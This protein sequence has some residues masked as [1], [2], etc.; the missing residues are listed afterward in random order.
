MRIP[1][2]VIDLPLAD[3]ETDRS[4]AAWVGGEDRPGW[5]R[6]TITRGGTDALSGHGAVLSSAKDARVR[7]I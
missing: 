4:E 3:T 6:P 7:R 1:P 2:S 5:R